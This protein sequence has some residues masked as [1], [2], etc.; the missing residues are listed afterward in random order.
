MAVVAHI[1]GRH[2]SGRFTESSRAVMAAD[3]A[4]DYGRMID[5]GNRGPAAAAMAILAEIGGRNVSGTLTCCGYAIV[6]TG[7]IT[8]DITVIEHGRCPTAGVVA[9][10]ASVTT[11]YMCGGLARCDSAVMAT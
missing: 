3:A 7:A 1:T 9:I 6:A 4:T 10:V 8:T 11:C 2:M 5:S